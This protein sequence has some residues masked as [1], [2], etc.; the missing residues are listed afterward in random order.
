LDKVE[1]PV[2]APLTSTLC[3]LCGSVVAQTTVGRWNINAE[4]A[5]HIRALLRSGTFAETLRIGEIAARHLNPDILSTDVQ[6][7]QSLAALSK[8]AEVLLREQQ[9]YVKTIADSERVDKNDARAGSLQEQK[10]IV[11]S[12]QKQI[13]E[14]H[15]QMNTVATRQFAETQKF[16]EAVLAIREKLVGTGIGPIEE[17]ALAKELKS[18]CPYD[19]FVTRQA[20]KGKADIVAEVVVKGQVIGKV[21]VSSKADNDWSEEFR[22]Q[23]RKNLMQE[24]TRWGILV[25][26]AFPSDALNDR[27]Y[28]DAEQFLLVKFP[29]AA[30]AY[31]GVREAVVHWHEAETRLTEVENRVKHETSVLQALGEW[32]RGEKFAE[33]TSKIDVARK[34]SKETEDLIEEWENYNKTK[35]QKIHQMQK[36][37]RDALG[38]CDGLLNDLRG[39]LN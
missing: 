6:V 25:T 3:P 18:A 27:A 26:K 29:Y 9:T 12:Y 17:A 11:E 36:K 21:V 5:E 33:F 20:T 24:R 13:L 23:L 10:Q 1:I 7:Q 19:N 34:F 37:L 8:K 2:A 35:A 14:L 39:R 16:T 30:V 4:E 32:V 31:L 15:Q 38:D 28:L 22:E